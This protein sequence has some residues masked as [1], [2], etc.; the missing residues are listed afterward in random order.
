MADKVIG[1]IGLG[2]MGKPMSKHL[3]KAGYRLVVR[4]VVQAAV[5]EVVAAG[6]RSAPTAREVAAQC[7]VLITM[8]PD[9]PDVEAVAYGPDGALAGLRPGTIWADMSTISPVTSRKV[10]ADAAKKSVQMLDAPVSGGE[11]GA[12]GATLSIMVGGPH[13]AFDALLPIFQIMG[14]TIVYL[15]AAGAGQVTKAANQIV[16]A[17]TIEAISEALVLASKA[18]VDPAKVRQVLLGGFCQSRILELHGERM[19]KREFAPGFKVRLHRKDLAI[20]LNAGKEF[21]VPLPVTAQVHEMLNALMVAGEGELDHS[22]IVHFIES[23]AKAEVRSA[24]G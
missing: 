6:A 5:D 4:D 17:L 1:F 22:A 3:L 8:V 23:G 10:A 18:G 14:K 9:S 2:I 24:G 13:D 7:D 15:G 20:A 16:V 12:I 19:I 11:K 21:G